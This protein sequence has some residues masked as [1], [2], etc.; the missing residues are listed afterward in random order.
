MKKQKRKI[1]TF[2]PFMAYDGEDF[3][4]NKKTFVIDYT[5]N[6]Q[7]YKRRFYMKISLPILR[8]TPPKELSKYIYERFKNKL[9]IR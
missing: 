3:R 4:N 8:Y 2:E 9:K 1:V 6:R 7:K 5:L